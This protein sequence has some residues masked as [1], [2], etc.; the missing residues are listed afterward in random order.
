VVSVE[1]AVNR[2]D[3][4]KPVGLQRCYSPLDYWTLLLTAGI[5]SAHPSDLIALL[6]RQLISDWLQRNVPRAQ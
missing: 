6:A 4:F 3:E 2:N 5:W 1:S